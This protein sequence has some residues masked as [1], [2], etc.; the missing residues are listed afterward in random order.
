MEKN[1]GPSEPWEKTQGPAPPL[2]ANLLACAP[3]HRPQIMAPT[4]NMDFFDG[5]VRPTLYNAYVGGC[6]AAWVGLGQAGRTAA[7]VQ[8]YACRVCAA[9]SL[10]QRAQRLLGS[11]PL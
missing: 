6:P 8:G 5:F 4:F 2:Q 11:W 9:G 1:A 10:G 3:L 7:A